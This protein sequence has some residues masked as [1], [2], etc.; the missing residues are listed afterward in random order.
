MKLSKR[1][2]EWKKGHSSY[3]ARAK[4]LKPQGKG[5]SFLNLGTAYTPENIQDAAVEGF[6]MDEPL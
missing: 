2:L 6:E 1:V 4:A 3:D 5:C